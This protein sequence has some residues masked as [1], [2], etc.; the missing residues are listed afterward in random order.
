MKAS[1]KAILNRKFIPSWM[2]EL[3]VVGEKIALNV[4]VT[5]ISDV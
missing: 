3:I 1:Q 4:M 5:A 2:T